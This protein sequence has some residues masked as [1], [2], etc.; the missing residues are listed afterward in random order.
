[1]TE[2][3]S[4]PISQRTRAIG[5]TINVLVLLLLSSLCGIVGFVWVPMVSRALPS[6]ST[7]ILGSS[8]LISCVLPIILIAGL[9]AAPV[10]G[11]Q[12]GPHWWPKFYARLES[13][14]FLIAMI[15]GAAAAILTGL[16]TVWALALYLDTQTHDQGAG[17]TLLAMFIFSPAIL[18]IGPMFGALGGLL[19][20]YIANR[21]GTKT[22]L[23][24][25]ICGLI[26]GGIAGIVAGVYVLFQL[27]GQTTGIPSL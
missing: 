15:P 24:I 6:A 8:G 9:V 4:T 23:I 16:C 2:L 5:C 7:Y 19:V 21:F 27:L 11:F 25:W 10:I 12:F 14:P 22:Q 1:M 3:S 20:S 18:L 26:G 17:Y 13:L